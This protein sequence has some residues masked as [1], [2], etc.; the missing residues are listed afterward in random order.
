MIQLCL[1]VTSRHF[2]GFKK[3]MY[4]IGF[5]PHTLPTTNTVL[6]EFRSCH[7]PEFSYC[8]QPI[9]YM[10]NRCSHGVQIVRHAEI[11]RCMN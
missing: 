2:N 6:A 1:H 5:V 11:I 8:L 7:L 3:R 10:G 9:D 4:Q